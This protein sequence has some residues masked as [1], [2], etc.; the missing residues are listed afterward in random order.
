MRVL[1]RTY[2]EVTGDDDRIDLDKLSPSERVIVGF[3]KWWV[4]TNF[5]IRK[6]DRELE[7]AH[8]ILTQRE[9]K[10]KSDILNEVYE[11][12]QNNRFFKTRG[13]EKY[14]TSAITLSVKRSDED[15]LTSVLRSKEFIS[16]HIEVLECDHDLL[17]SYPKLPIMVKFRRKT[18]G[19]DSI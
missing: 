17:V 5:Y 15:I 14:T 10:L 7:K 12:L 2:I 11:E 8:R 13:D 9:D 18:L 6:R 19:G 4:R 3:K 1:V 16:Y